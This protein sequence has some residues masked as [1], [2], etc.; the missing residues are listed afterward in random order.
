MHPSPPG[1]ASA[2]TAIADIIAIEDEIVDVG[3]SDADKNFDTS[4]ITYAIE[5]GGGQEIRLRQGQRLVLSQSRLV[6]GTDID[7]DLQTHV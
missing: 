4:E 2:A 7:L 5:K 6:S 3:F 1:A